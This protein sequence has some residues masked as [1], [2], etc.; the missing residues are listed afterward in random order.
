MGIVGRIAGILGIA[1]GCASARE[2][3]LTVPKVDLPRYMGEWY[4]IASIPL[5][6]ERDAW[7]AVESY[8]LAPDG[9][10]P[11][12][13]TFR[14]GGFAEPLKTYESTGFPRE[15]G[16]GAEWDIQF[17]WPLKAEYLVIAL[18]PDYRW[19]VVGRNR[20]DHAWILS[21]TS[22]L[23]EGVYERL[24]EDLAGVGYDTSKLVKIP[25]RSKR[26]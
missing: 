1:I 21:R 9:S 17:V 4:V 24:V 5:W 6:L 12:V 23:P 26:N 13:F 18:D 2:P 3:L 15:D 10:V 20:R 14:R 11:T 25:H 16:H 22:T 19:A 7:D 8:K